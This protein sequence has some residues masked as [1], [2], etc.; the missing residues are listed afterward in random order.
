[1]TC[2]CSGKIFTEYRIYFVS[3]ILSGFLPLLMAAIFG[4]MAYRSV[5]SIAYRTLP[6]I[7]REL[8]KQLTSIVLVLVVFKLLTISPALFM[9]A[10]TINRNITNNAVVWAQLELIATITFVLSY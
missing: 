7:R 1:M 6:L 9:N 4:I 8:D 10:L 2:A 5:Q 3:P